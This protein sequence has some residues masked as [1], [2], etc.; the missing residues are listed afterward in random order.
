MIFGSLNK[1]IC[2]GDGAKILENWTSPEF[3]T[4]SCRKYKVSLDLE[5]KTYLQYCPC[6]IVTH[7]QT[8]TTGSEAC[9]SLSK[10]KQSGIDRYTDFHLSQFSKVYNLQIFLKHSKF[11]KNICFSLKLIYVHYSKR[12]LR[13]SSFS[14]NSSSESFNLLKEKL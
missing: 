11:G 2:K 1:E 10:T 4:D 12:K 9:I 13:K 8:V 5:K 6:G 7:V 14:S 3:A